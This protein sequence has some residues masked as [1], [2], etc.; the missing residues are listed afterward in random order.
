MMKSP[1]APQRVSTLDVELVTLAEAKAHLH[2]DALDIS[3]DPFIE[4]LIEA[5]ISHIDGY[6][7]I[8]GRCL[9]NQVWD[10]H[11]DTWSRCWRLPFPDVSAASITVL[12]SDDTSSSVDEASYQVLADHIGSYVRFR[13]GYS[14]PSDIAESQGWTV[15]ITAG[16]G[17][18]VDD[19][20]KSIKQSVLQMVGQWFINRDE[21]ATL[22]Y[23]AGILLAQHRRVGL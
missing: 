3:E 22:P 5:A 18:E 12:A 4:G 6:S 13:T 10:V 15:R 11:F 7:G 8:L 1:Y 14:P 23:A 2:I 20:P 19:V 9:I 17:P 21:A 16:Y